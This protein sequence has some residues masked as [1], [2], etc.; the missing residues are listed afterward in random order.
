M[1]EILLNSECH[2]FAN[3]PHIETHSYC[4]AALDKSIQHQWPLVPDMVYLVNVIR[5]RLKNTLHFLLI[6][7]HDEM[8]S[9]SISRHINHL[10][11][12]HYRCGLSAMLSA[13]SERKSDPTRE[14]APLFG[15]PALFYKW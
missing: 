4:I 14:T 9:I 12:Y 1:Q 6:S 3:S 13:Q 11:V 15:V 5:R 2:R 8:K 10:T 7:A